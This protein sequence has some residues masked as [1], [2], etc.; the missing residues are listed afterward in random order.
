MEHPCCFSP[1]CPVGCRSEHG[2]SKEAQK[3]RNKARR[4]MSKSLC[5]VFGLNAPPPT[6][7]SR[8]SA[9]ENASC[10]LHVRSNTLETRKRWLAMKSVLFV[11]VWFRLLCVVS[12]ACESLLLVWRDAREKS[13]SCF[14]LCEGVSFPVER[15]V[16]WPF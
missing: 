12:N 5:S 14:I 2:L 6:G 3:K 9:R 11:S 15:L 8:P 10:R 7:T 16:D 1:S 13:C 4:E